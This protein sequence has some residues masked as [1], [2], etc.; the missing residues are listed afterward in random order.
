[1]TKQAEAKMKFVRKVTGY[2]VEDQIKNTVI[3]DNPNIFD[4]NKMILM[5]KLNVIHH[6]EK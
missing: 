1:M 6:V 4:V 5:D 2:A 3:R